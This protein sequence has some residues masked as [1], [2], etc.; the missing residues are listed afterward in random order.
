MLVEYD[1]KPAAMVSPRYL[2]A[3]SGSALDG[4]GPALAGAARLMRARLVVQR[5][6]P[7]TSRGGRRAL[8]AVPRGGHWRARLEPVKARPAKARE[9]GA[10]PGRRS[11][12]K[13]RKRRG[14][15]RE[16]CKARQAC[17]APVPARARQEGSSALERGGRR[18]SMFSVEAKIGVIGPSAGGETVQNKFH[19]LIKRPHFKNIFFNPFS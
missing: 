4:A 14:Q 12:T 7:A 17:S 15:R 3:V 16:A 11:K 2:A 8:G 18:D 1:I 6:P 13:Q 5:R 9:P 10:G 19:Q